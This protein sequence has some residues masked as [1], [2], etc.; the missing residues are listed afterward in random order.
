MIKPSLLEAIQERILLADG[1]I[2]TEIYARGVFFNRC[3]D[4]I[5]LSDPRLI[6]EIHQDYLRAGA[7]LIETNTFGANRLRLAA[8]GLEDK[9][10]DINRRGVEIALE[11]AQGRA[12]VAGAM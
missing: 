4:E 1:G 9:V 8:Y 11:A 3:Y 5:N 12:Y 10:A 6:E 7:D 2:G